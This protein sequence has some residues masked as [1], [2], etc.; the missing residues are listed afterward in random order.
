LGGRILKVEGVKGNKLKKG[1]GGLRRREEY[2]M[3][4]KGGRKRMNV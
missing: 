4:R 3:L 2:L 1:Q